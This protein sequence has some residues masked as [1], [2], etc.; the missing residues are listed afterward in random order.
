MKKILAA[1]V[2]IVAG[3]GAAQAGCPVF[4]VAF[5]A[6]LEGA[7]LFG[8]EDVI[9]AVW[10][11]GLTFS[12]I[13]WTANYMK[14]RGVKNRGWY[15]LNFV[16][17]YGLLSLV[18]FVPTSLPYVVFKANCMWGIDQFLL[19]T[20]VGS[21]VFWAMEKWY[22]KIKK[23]NGGH[24]KYPFQKVVMPFMGLVGATLVLWAMLH[25]LPAM[26]IVIC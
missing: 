17:Y 9:V 11:G 12:L 21:V 14:K 1:L 5:G 18:Y 10:A 22:E 15:I 19:G 7:R 13:G 4:T 26:G 6:A 16:A 20:I 25:W 23:N 24:A 8:V 3:F 2:A